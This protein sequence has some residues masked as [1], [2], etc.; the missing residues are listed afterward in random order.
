M[1]FCERYEPKGERDLG[2]TQVLRKNKVWASKPWGA[3]ERVGRETDPGE[4]VRGKRG[5]RQRE[6]KL[7]NTN[8]K[9]SAGR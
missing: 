3:G 5:S 7:T 2:S 8:V 6:K 1:H 4:S 9:T